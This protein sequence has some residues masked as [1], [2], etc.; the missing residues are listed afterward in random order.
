MADVDARSPLNV[1]TCAGCRDLPGCR[2]GLGEI[3]VGDV[4]TPLATAACPVEYEAGPG[5]AHGGWTAA[6]LDE[7]LGKSL[8]QYGHLAVTVE[9]LTRYLRPVPV[10]P[11]L[12]LEGWLIGVVGDRWTVG[13]EVRLAS[14]GKVLA[15]GRGTWLERTAQ[16][17]ER[18]LD[19]L[20]DEGV[21]SIVEGQ[22]RRS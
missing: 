19:V 16:H 22:P 20:A 10:G 5:T 7:F 12:E 4:F 14:T 6:V 18:H 17:W 9:L 11:E 21:E 3:H 15:T 13:G 8:L 1:G 2:F